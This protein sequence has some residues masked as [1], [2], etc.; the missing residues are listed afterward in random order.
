MKK[1]LEFI[2]VWGMR[3]TTILVLVVFLK[4]CTT[5]TRIEKVEKQVQI[6]K[7]QTNIPV[8]VGFGIKTPEDAKSVSAIADGVVVGSSIVELIEKNTPIDKI[9]NYIK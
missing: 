2:D 6:I 3:I 1:L 9:C 5:N 8:C 4:T 7:S